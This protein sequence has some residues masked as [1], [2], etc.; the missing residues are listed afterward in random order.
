MIYIEKYYNYLQYELHLEKN[1]ISSYLNDLKQFDKYISELGMD[2]LDV[3]E[4]TLLNFL[5]YSSK[6][7]PN[8]KAHYITVLNS[9]FKFLYIK[10]YIEKDVTNL[11]THPK[12]QSKLVDYLTI[13]EVYQLADASRDIRE[14]LIVLLMFKTGIRVSEAC[15]ITLND[16]N[17]KEK[18]IKIHGKGNKERIVLFDNEV[19]ELLNKYLSKTKIEKNLLLNKKGKP[20][21]RFY[22][23]SLLKELANLANIKKNIYPHIL[24]HSFATYMLEQGVDLRL[25]QVMLGHEDITTT[26]IYTHILTKHLKS[27]YNKYHPLGKGEIENE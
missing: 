24:R 22:I 1:T 27:C 6:L 17:I 18:T 19:V 20:C 3:N 15:N 25:L 9:Y 10:K 26:T 13:N 14:R 16:I 5:D 4:D 12:K 8:S 7:K 2:E 21:D 11:L 23:Y